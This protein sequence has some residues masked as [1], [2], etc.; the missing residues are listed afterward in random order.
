MIFSSKALQTKLKKA[1]TESITK[2]ELV[3]NCIL[4]SCYIVYCSQMTIDE[5]KRMIKFYTRVCKHYD[6]SIPD[7]LIFKNL[8]LVNVFKS[9]EQ[10][11]FKA[12]LNPSGYF[13]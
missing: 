10:L 3:T 13:Y 7:K 2:E 9:F 8:K 11:F 5:R 6:L 12:S 1:Y 4:A